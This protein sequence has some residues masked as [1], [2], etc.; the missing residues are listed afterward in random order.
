M[1][2]AV[3][4]A[5]AANYFV[6]RQDWLD[7]RTEEI[8]EP[9]LPI[10]DPHHHLWDRG[11]WRYLHESTEN[12]SDLS[13][14]SWQ[15]LFLRA[16]KNA[17]FEVP[18]DRIDEASAYV[19]RC[20]DADEKTF[21]YVALV[22]RPLSRGMAGAGVLSMSLA[23]KHD[24]DIALVTG[25]WILAHPFTPYRN[26]IHGGYDRYFYSL[27][28][29]T[30]AMFQLGG[31]YWRAFYPDAVKV[32]LD[33]QA[34]PGNWDVEELGDARFGQVYTTALCVLTLDTPY[35]LLPIFQR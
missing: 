13:V 29:C 30:Q 24:S 25:V 21:Q 17:G 10:I 4:A 5:H 20:Y 11:G 28:Y 33:N 15:L 16:M 35:Q 1:A 8:L 9:A 32:L 27:F 14:T 2:E 19:E 3:P 34:E 7:R 6:V 18:A 23:G 22:K 31:N 12:L 26:K